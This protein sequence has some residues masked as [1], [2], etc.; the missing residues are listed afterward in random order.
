MKILIR[1]LDNVVV[2]AQDDLDLTDTGAS[3]EGWVNR[4]L[5]TA[6]ARI[7]DAP[8]PEL[9]AAGIWT[10]SGGVWALHNQTGYDALVGATLN[11]QIKAKI[12]VLESSITERMWREALIGK[13][14]VNAQTGKTSKQQ[15]I[16]IDAAIAA[17][18]EQLRK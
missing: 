1:D 9:F 15:I 5:T 4:H 10:Y 12:A 18:R 13:T 2:Y 11:P 7:E 14:D 6:N 8:M 3:G 17:L 16:D